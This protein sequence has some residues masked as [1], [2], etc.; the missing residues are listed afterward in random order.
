MSKLKFILFLLALPLFYTGCDQAEDDLVTETAVTGGLVEP[1]NPNL[2]Y[3]VGDVSRKY[4]AEI[5]VFQGDVKTSSIDV[6]KQFKGVLGTSQNLLWKTVTPNQNG[7]AFSSF[8]FDYNELRAGLNIPGVGEIPAD[9]TQLSIGDKWVLT[10][11]SKTSEGNSHLNSPTT[12]STSVAVSTRYAG[13][14]EVIASD[15]WRIGAQSGAANWVGQER[16]IESVDATTYY[17]K[18]FGPFTLEDDARAFFYFKVNGAD[19]S[20][21]PEFDGTAITGLGAYIISCDIEPNNMTNVPCGDGVTDYIQNDD[22]TGADIIYMSYGY[23]TASG[24]VGP[25]E[26]HEVLRKKVN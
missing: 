7:T 6:Y 16:I 8:E 1:Q 22:E 5:K 2:N 23:Y 10:Y 18:G 24:A 14:Y 11:V 3:V 19:V 21:L 20:Y 17:H 13:T 25:R 4:A 9:D 15:Y 26:F 12:A